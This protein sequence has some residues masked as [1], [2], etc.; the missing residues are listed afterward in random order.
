MKISFVIPCYRSERTLGGV[1]SEVKS[2]LAQRPETDYEFVLVSDHS[3]DNVW[4]VIKR[5]HDS[6]P[7]RI[8]GLELARNFG[9]HA[10]LMAGYARTTGDLV[11]SLDDD[12]QAPV[13]SIW[14]LVDK[15]LE[16]NF[17]V[18]YG[19]YGKKRHSSF[20]N[21]GSRVNDRMAECL[22]DKPKNVRVSSF[23]IARRFVVDEVVK[24]TQPFPYVLGLV[25]RVTRNVGEM[26]VRHRNRA[27]GTSSYT[28]LKLLSLWVNGFTAFSV[29]PLRLA[30]LVGVLS[31][32]GGFLG[33]IWA[34]VNKLFIHPQAPIGYSSFMSS[35][36]F[37]GGIIMLMLGLVG[38]YVGRIY[39]CINR[40][41]QYVIGRDAQETQ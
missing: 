30:S 4:N 29:K 2:V 17:D 36:F 37:I 32:L 6:D 5:L 9:Q 11:F 25:L 3:P 22:L 16:E 8:K 26:E 33:G 20:R 28:F 38:E 14:A 23:F 35:L 39:I 40:S 12:G 41:P 15:L 31:S 27:E 1:V 24:Y 19:A 21:F 34:V 13:E 7:A 18:V 10:A